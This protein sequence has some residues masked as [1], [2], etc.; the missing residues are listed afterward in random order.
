MKQYY[1]PGKLLISGEYLVLKGS[2][3]FAVP[4]KFGQKMQVEEMDDS[5][6]ILHWKAFL[7]DSSIWF[8]CKIQMSD[9]SLLNTTD[10]LKSKAL[11]KLLNSAKGL[12]S[13][14]LKGRSFKVETYLEFDK[15][16]GLGSSSTLI[17]NIAKWAEVDAFALSEQSFGGSGYDIAVGMVGSELLYSYPPAWDSFVW[18]PAFRNKLFFVYLNRKQNS[19]D[20]IKGFEA[21]SISTS[22]IERISKI[23][24]EIVSSTDL[25][26]FQLLISEHEKILSKI[27]NLPTVKESAFK[28]YPFAIKSLGAWG[29]DFIL[30]CGGESDMNYFRGKGYNTIFSYQELIK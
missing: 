2:E 26:Y 23:S 27:L 7:Q 3:A 15:D 30:A 22:E 1:S 14:F 25:D 17:C 13:E 6:N 12:N 24:R 20:A 29:G 4:C 19:R 18:N 16:W 11:L 28:D 9:M 10:E 5:D 21:L 8:E